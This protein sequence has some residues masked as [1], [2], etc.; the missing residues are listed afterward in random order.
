[1]NS[2]EVKILIVILRVGTKKK[3]KKCAENNRENQ[4]GTLEK[5]LV[6]TEGSNGET[7]A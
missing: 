5:K 4:S 1:M 3:N 7:K 6:T 2:C